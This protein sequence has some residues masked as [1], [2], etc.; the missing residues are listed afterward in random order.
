MFNS[1][2]KGSRSTLKHPFIVTVN[3]GPKP[4]SR[5]SHPGSPTE[6]VDPGSYVSFVAVLLVGHG[7]A[8]TSPRMASPQNRTSGFALGNG[9]L[10]KHCQ[11][12]EHVILCFMVVKNLSCSGLWCGLMFDMSFG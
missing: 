8:G 5:A 1:L 12:E 2:L 9:R 4:T 10:Q 7:N 3:G 6:F 11:R